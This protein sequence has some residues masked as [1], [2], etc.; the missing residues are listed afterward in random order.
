MTRRHQFETDPLDQGAPVISAHT[1][2]TVAQR[3]RAR[4]YVAANAHDT[5][6]LRD[7]LG[8]L[9]L[10]DPTEIT[11]QLAHRHQQGDQT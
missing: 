3:A 10:N 11:A 8:Y 1:R 4:R 9:G 6:D 2:T 5:D 7:L